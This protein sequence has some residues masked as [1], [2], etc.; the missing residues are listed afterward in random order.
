MRA[1]SAPSAEE[2]FSLR[3][4]LDSIWS[5]FKLSIT[6]L[7]SGIASETTKATLLGSPSVS[8]IYG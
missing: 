5:F 8:S 6:S 3:R 1:I 7:R 2:S 4:G